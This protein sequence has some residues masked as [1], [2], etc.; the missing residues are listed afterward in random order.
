MRPVHV[1][2]LNGEDVIVPVREHIE[3]GDVIIPMKLLFN[4][5]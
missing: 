2:L 1:L 3:T 4:A 5:L